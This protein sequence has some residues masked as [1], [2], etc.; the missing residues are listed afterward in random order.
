V[1]MLLAEMCGANHVAL[2]VTGGV[3]LV[4]RVAHWIGLPRPAPNP[5]RFAGIALT[6]LCIVGISVYVLY[7]RFQLV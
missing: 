7:L 3:L 2:H 1:M 4:A 5:Y 6:W